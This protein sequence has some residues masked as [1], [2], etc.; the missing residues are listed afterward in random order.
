MCWFYNSLA[1]KMLTAFLWIY[2]ERNLNYKT[3]I[4]LA[5]PESCLAL[6]TCSGITTDGEYWVYPTVTNRRRTKIYCHS[7]STEPSHFI[8]LKYPNSFVGH[9]SSNL[10]TRA[11]CR[12][13]FKPPLRQTNFT[14]VKIQIEVGDSIDTMNSIHIT[15]ITRLRFDVMLSPSLFVVLPHLTD[16]LFYSKM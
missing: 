8:T 7:L 15:P 10:I 16:F 9:G 2:Y 5:A 14:K 11:R 4:F 6:S 1:R 3:N 12:S 13:E